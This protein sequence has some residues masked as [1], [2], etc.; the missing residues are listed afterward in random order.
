MPHIEEQELNEINDLKNKLA[1]LITEVG[2]Q[3]LK[4]ELLVTE[5]EDLQGKISKNS[6]LF[7]DLLKTEQEVINRLSNKYG[8]GTIN[9]ETGEFTPE[10]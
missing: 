9:F 10:K 8:A 5:I 4:V 2:Q 1:A 6:S 3:Q 7:K